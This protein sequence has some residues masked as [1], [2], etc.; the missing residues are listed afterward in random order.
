MFARWDA[1][2]IRAAESIALLLTVDWILIR[3]ILAIHVTITCPPLRDAVPIVT[4][5]VG[6]LTGMIDGSTVGFIRPVPAVVVPITHP[7]GADAHARAAVVLIVPALVPFTVTFI[8]VV[9]T[10][11]FK[12]TFVGQWDTGPRLL[13]TELGIQITNGSRAISLI[14]H[15]P[16]VVVKV[17][18]P[19]AVDT[20]PVAAAILVEETSVLF[21]DTGVVPQL[22]AL[23][24]LTHQVPRW[25]DTAGHTLW[26]PAALTVV[27]LRQAE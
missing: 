23:R 11:I 27:G 6:S 24:A 5:E 19:N 26:T 15:V 10:V 13:A 25:E 3:T 1:G 7:G 14:T 8:A 12:I 18:P 17:T 4:L 9:S 22:I 16:T 20:I 21:F 2:A